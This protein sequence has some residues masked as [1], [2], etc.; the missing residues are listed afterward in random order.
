[1]FRAYWLLITV[2]LAAIWA[3]EHPAI[4]LIERHCV[5]CHQPSKAKGGLDLT[6]RASALVGGDDGPSVVPGKAG[7]SPLYRRTTHQDEPGMPAKK[8]KLADSE[9]ALLRQWIDAGASWTRT[10]TAQAASDRDHWSFR[11]HLRPAIPT[12]RD[13]AWIRTPVDAFVRSAQEARGLSPT[14][15][16][17]RVRLIRR[18]TVDLTGLPPE[19]DLL[20]TTLNDTRSWAR[21]ASAQAAMSTHP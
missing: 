6:T 19:P 5:S 20:L 14:P 10:L 17:D 18:V 11:P 4:N 15:G 21:K 2:S 3:A 8:P 12:P 9:I 13:R 7:D 16:I 1:M